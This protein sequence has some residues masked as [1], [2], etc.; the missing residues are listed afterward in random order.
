MF[1]MISG[2]FGNFKNIMMAVGAALL[3]GYVAKQKYDSYKAQDKLKTIENK[4]AKANVSIAKKTAKAKATA[5]EIENDSEIS[6]L[7]NLKVERK[8]VLKEMDDAE[9]LIASTQKEKEEVKGRKKGKTVII[10]A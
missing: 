4:I 1:T 5:K 8:K 3:A 6:V 10:N 9:Q 7:R 2:F